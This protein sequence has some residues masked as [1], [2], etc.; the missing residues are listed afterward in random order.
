M[1]KATGLRSYN[2]LERDA[3]S[4]RPVELY[5]SCLTHVW[6]GDGSSRCLRPL[7]NEFWQIVAQQ[8]K[9]LPCSGA[10]D[11]SAGTYYLGEGCTLI[12]M[13]FFHHEAML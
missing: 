8:L 4:L 11:L 6:R 2:S 13:I 1:L 10:S 5:T 12:K 9:V 7:T 3:A